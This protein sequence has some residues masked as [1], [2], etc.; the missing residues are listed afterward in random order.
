MPV[1]NLVDTRKAVVGGQNISHSERLSPEYFEKTCVC[2]GRKFKPTPVQNMHG[3]MV[4]NKN[5]DT[6]VQCLYY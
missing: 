4:E 3:V 1:D 5:R 6:C 2:C